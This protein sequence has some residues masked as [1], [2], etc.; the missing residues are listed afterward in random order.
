LSIDKPG[1]NIIREHY[2]DGSMDLIIARLT[3]E[4]QQDWTR[5]QITDRAARLGIKR[6]IIREDFPAISVAYHIEGIKEPITLIASDF[7]MPWYNRDIC[8]Q[9]VQVA[10]EKKVPS[11]IIAGD[12]FDNWIFSIFDKESRE[13]SWREE[14]NKIDHLFDILLVTIPR[15]YVIP[16][17]HDKRML[18]AL[19][20]QVSFPELFRLLE[21]GSRVKVL[22]LPIVKLNEDSLILHPDTYSR[23]PGKVP[24]D[25][26]AKY[27]KNVFIGHT[28]S[29]SLVWDPSAKNVGIE[30]GCMCQQDCMDYKNIHITTHPQ[31]NPGFVLYDHG[32][33]QLYNP[34]VIW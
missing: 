22:E 17:N 4:T 9:L 6:G 21:N 18:R 19:K 25:L 1:D 5:K 12:L 11:L 30:V 3:N 2:V 7:H 24:R 32:N 31:W 13:T 27:R 34:L 14:R 20:F 28:H 15:I 10:K 16:G 26:I 8:M 29:Q 33:V 23:T